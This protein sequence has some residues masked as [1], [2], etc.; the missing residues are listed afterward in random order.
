MDEFYYRFHK[1]YSGD[2]NGSDYLKYADSFYYTF[3][4]LTPVIL[5]GEL[6]VGEIANNLNDIEK[7]EWEE[8]YKNIAKNRCASA[9]DGQDSHMAIDYVLLL[10]H[11][12]NGIILR[13]GDYLKVCAE[14]KKEFYLAAQICLKAVVKHSENYAN[15]AEIL[16]KKEK[17]PFR[18][19]E[20]LRI[21][22][23]CKNVPANPARNFYE[24]VQSI[25]FVTYCL[26]L[27]P[28]RYNC[29]QFQLGRLDRYLISYYQ[30]DIK[31][32]AITKEKAQLLLDCLGIQMNMRVHSGLSSGYMV[33]GRDE[34]GDITANELT[35]ML[36][37]VVDDIKL[38][39]PAVGLCYGIIDFM[40]T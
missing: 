9:G 13:I 22:E 37:Q 1:Q 36:M 23:I 2:F 24:A 38:V 20:L 11:G 34:K 33:G 29:Q 35:E 30:Q 15:H 4:N 27:N 12:I 10:E 28:L 8:I 3:A 19:N 31:N 26:S 25:H 21:A 7:R 6:I 5:D 32:G 17:D 18:K 39:Y 16:A 14:D 40:S